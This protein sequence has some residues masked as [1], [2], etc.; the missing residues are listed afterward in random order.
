INDI[1]KYIVCGGWPDKINLDEKKCIKALAFYYTSLINEDVNNIDGVKRNPH[2]VDSLLKSFSRNI[3][4]LSKYSTIL[5]DMRNNNNGIDIKTLDS[6]INTLERLFVIENIKA[7]SPKIRSKYAIRTADKKLLVDPSLACI[8]LGIDSE[9]LLNDYKTFGFLFEAL[10]LRDLRIYIEAIDG[11]IYH[12]YDQSGLE[13]DAILSL[14]N[15]DWAGIEIKLGSSPDVINGA[16]KSLKKLESSIDTNFS[17]KP[18]FLAVVTGGKFAYK[19]D[20]VYV[21][22]L[23]MLKN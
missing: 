3:A 14:R 23:T 6:Y 1:A 22:P 20:G 21:I 7:W 17:K 19:V 2:I 8:S 11:Q 12:Y 4:T 9:Y 5:E 10:A 18:K 15:G 16:I 13:V